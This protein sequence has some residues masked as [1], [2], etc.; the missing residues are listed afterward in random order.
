MF[1]QPLAIVLV[2]ALLAALA[3]SCYGPAGVSPTTSSS[4][5]APIPPGSPSSTAG[6]VPYE[7]AVLDKMA[8][9]AWV[10]VSESDGHWWVGQYGDAGHDTGMTRTSGTGYASGN[11]VVIDEQSVR[12]ATV[13]L[14]DASTGEWLLVARELSP[15]AAAVHG[16]PGF[17]GQT[18]VADSGDGSIGTVIEYGPANPLGRL[19]VASAGGRS[20]QLVILKL[21]ASRS[22]LLHSYCSESACRGT[23]VG[24][25]GTVTLAPDL[26]PV[27]TTDHSVLAFE[28]LE[29]SSWVVV[30]IKSGHRTSLVDPDGAIRRPISQAI[31]LDDAT[32]LVDRGAEL[33][34]IDARDGSVRVLVSHAARAGWE[35]TGSP[36]DGRWVLLK[37]VK[38]EG[39]PVLTSAQL[40]SIAVLDLQS[41]TITESVVQLPFSP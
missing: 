8:G 28:D 24:P 5:D 23:V 36:I 18:F 35:I 33:F 22:T 21:S 27:A 25:E 20:G 41:G 38:V 2:P 26:F 34:A 1:R 4:S 15:G 7:Q 19:V 30:D 11:Q 9:Q 31:P 16:I 12:G 39:D 10:G 29:G 17:T 32:F 6:V 37:R 13:Y 3:A 14:V 40:R